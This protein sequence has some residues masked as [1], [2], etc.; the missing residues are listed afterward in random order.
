M[1]DGAG[2]PASRPP[3]P[4]S[5]AS[6]HG[7]VVTSVSGSNATNQQQNEFSAQNLSGASTSAGAS[8]SSVAQGL[9]ALNNPYLS[10]SASSSQANGASGLGQGALEASVPSSS[11]AT[12]GSVPAV[13]TEALS[14]D[15][16]EG[17]NTEARKVQTSLAYID[18]AAIRARIDA[19]LQR[20]QASA[21][22]PDYWT[23]FTS[24]Q[25]II[26]RLLPYH[27]W[28]VSDDDLRW[29][30]APSADDLELRQTLRARAEAAKTRAALEGKG[31]G[32]AKMEDE[33]HQLPAADGDEQSSSLSAPGSQK[34]QTHVAKKRRL[35]RGS[36]SKDPS[37]IAKS[38]DPPDIDQELDEEQLVFGGACA[39]PSLPKAMSFYWAGLSLQHRIQEVCVQ[40]DGG[41]PPR[42]VATS[43]S[44]DSADE[45]D[46]LVAPAQ[47]FNVSL[48]YLERLAYEDEKSEYLKLSAEYRT[49][50][51]RIDALY[52]TMAAAAAPPPANRAPHNHAQAQQ[53]RS[54]APASRASTSG[55]S[56]PVNQQHLNQSHVPSGTI[57]PTIPTTPIPLLIPLGNLTQLLSMNINPEPA[58]NIAAAFRKVLAEKPHLAQSPHSLMLAAERIARNAR[59]RRAQITSSLGSVTPS[60]LDPRVQAE[61]DELDSL[62]V[63][64][65]SAPQEQ[66]EASLLTGISISNASSPP[67]GQAGAPSTQKVPG[68]D[69]FALPSTVM[70]HISVVLAKLT[71]TQLSA[72]AALMT[73][74]QNQAQAQTRPP[75]TPNA[76]PAAPNQNQQQ[77]RPSS[78][79]QQATPQAKSEPQ[80]HYQQ[81]QTPTQPQAATMSTSSQAQTQLRY[82]TANQA[83]RV[84][85]ATPPHQT[86][87]LSGSAAQ[88]P[89]PMKREQ[90]QQGPLPNPGPGPTT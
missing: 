10:S 78:Y 8:S 12:L 37:Y 85:Q 48:E 53:Y 30:L 27:V 3:P 84:T 39:F 59:T 87:S 47:N 2:P 63:S 13:K 18:P 21:L 61:L 17:D 90:D 56:T 24:T 16:I 46:T 4:P 65:R 25:D 76:A 26:N 55:H 35:T 32:K 22:K 40:A 75:G 45:G 41:L 80:Q 14:F 60:T 33:E 58:S 15:R 20:N 42:D 68:P 89:S 73:S 11:A 81:P 34:E 83:Q 7:V 31:K 36:I 1:A 69:E 52:R 57:N 54:P 62:S 44:A 70:L 19:A 28:N 86:S 29:A 49:A 38:T 67:N 50:K 23:P 71:A 64:P 88:V 74:L 6:Q 43:L 51:A 5:S 9:P 77:Q 66:V 72:L 79:P 82:P